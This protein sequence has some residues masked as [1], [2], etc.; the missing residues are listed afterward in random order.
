M[1]VPGAA[2]KLDRNCGRGN[3]GRFTGKHIS[4]DQ[5][6]EGDADMDDGAKQPLSS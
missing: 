2:L 5:L 3:F 1:V 4:V 6:L